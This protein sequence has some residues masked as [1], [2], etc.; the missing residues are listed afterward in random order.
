[1]RKNV[2]GKVKYTDPDKS[3]GYIIEEGSQ[4]PSETILFELDDVEE[5]PET[6]APGSDVEFDVDEAPES[7]ARQVRPA[8]S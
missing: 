2:K 8:Y 4:D 5:G 3:Y 6:L 1:M 7:Q